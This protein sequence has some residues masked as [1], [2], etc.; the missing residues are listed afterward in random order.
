MDGIDQLAR[1]LA[2]VDRDAG[3]SD[4]REIGGE[5]LIDNLACVIAIESI[6][7]ID[8]EIGGEFGVDTAPDLFVGGEGD[9]DI[10]AR[11]VGVFQQMT[12]GGHDDGDARLVI[13]AQKR[14]AGGGDDIFADL[15]SEIG[16]IIGAEREVG[17][18]G[19]ADR[20]AIVAADH[21]RLYAGR[22]ELRRGIDMGE[23]ADGRA[24]AVA[25]DGGDDGAVGGFGDIGRADL[26]QFGHHQVEHRV[27][28]RGRGLGRAVHVRLAVDGGV[29]DKPLFQFL[30]EIAHGLSPV[31]KMISPAWWWLVNGGRKRPL[32]RGTRPVRAA[33]GRAGGSGS[34]LLHR[35]SREARFR[36]GDRAG[37]RDG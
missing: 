2:G 36:S 31:C 26:G 22:V 3:D 11:Q 7:E 29:T 5:G 33:G 17:G 25:G 1:R 19:K 8:A 30:I 13:G 23:K 16:E 4:D 35:P 14:G 24:G 9:A 10:G 32:R 15:G 6:G 28:D 12:R 21:A 20:A 27:L 18:I 37:D 34:D